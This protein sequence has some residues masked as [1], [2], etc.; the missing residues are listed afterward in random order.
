MREQ[1]DGETSLLFCFMVAN[2]Y[3]RCRTLKLNKMK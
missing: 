2:Y 1:T 3:Y